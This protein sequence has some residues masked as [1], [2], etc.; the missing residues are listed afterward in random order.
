MF[1]NKMVEENSLD[2]LDKPNVSPNFDINQMRCFLYD[3]IIDVVEGRRTVNREDF[4]GNMGVYYMVLSITSNEQDE[5]EPYQDPETRKRELL[6]L[7]W[8]LK[9]RL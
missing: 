3:Y 2:N 8:E 1:P 9:N 5:F 6:E 7:C 4:I